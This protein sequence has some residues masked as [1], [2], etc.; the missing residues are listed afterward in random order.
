MIF[1]DNIQTIAKLYDN[2]AKVY[3]NKLKNF[4]DYEELLKFR[5]NLLHR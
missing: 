5:D 3:V 4:D 2:G 1:S